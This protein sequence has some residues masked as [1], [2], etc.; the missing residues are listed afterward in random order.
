MGRMQPGQ[1]NATLTSHLGKADAMQPGRD[2]YSS[3]TCCSSPRKVTQQTPVTRDVSPAPLLHCHGVAGAML[4]L[5]PQT[6][7]PQPSRASLAAPRE[8]DL[9]GQE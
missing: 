5:P 6:I 2:R 4:L 7:T 3:P 9:Q 1:I 8:P